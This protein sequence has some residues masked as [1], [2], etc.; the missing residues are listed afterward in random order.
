M[1]K[2]I[3]RKRNINVWEIVNYL[4]ASPSIK[5]KYTLVVSRELTMS[6]HDASRIKV[7]NNMV[8]WLEENTKFPILYSPPDKLY[9]RNEN[10]ASL[11]KLTFP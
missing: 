6:E 10:E 5:Q 2:F 8:K 11:F 4:P 7:W 1:Y 9:F 3:R